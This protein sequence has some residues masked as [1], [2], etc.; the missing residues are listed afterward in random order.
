MSST[1]VRVSRSVGFAISK[2]I[3]I[4][5]QA[6]DIRIGIGQPDVS[7]GA[8]EIKSAVADTG[9]S[10]RRAPLELIQRDAKRRACRRE[11]IPRSTV[12]VDLPPQRRERRKIIRPVRKLDPG[13]PVSGTDCSRLAFTQRAVVVRDVDLRD[14]PEE[15]SAHCR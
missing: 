15:K 4:V 9:D 2:S 7:I 6:R 8:N 1:A 3:R 13:K 5:S 12:H 11:V 10:R 14:G